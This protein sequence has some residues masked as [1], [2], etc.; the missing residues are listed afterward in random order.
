[1]L[2]EVRSLRCAMHC[3]ALIVAAIVFS[4]TR[5]MST[6]RRMSKLATTAVE[7][8]R[9]NALISLRVPVHDTD[10]KGRRKEE[11]GRRNTSL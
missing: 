3:L 2:R 11:G 9:Q 4:R 5:E 10:R 6:A 8:K 7:A 1:M